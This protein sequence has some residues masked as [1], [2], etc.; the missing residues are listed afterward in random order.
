[1]IKEHEQEDI[2]SIRSFSKTYVIIDIYIYIYFQNIWVM[3]IKL[4]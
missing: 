1:M 4:P 3:P 2:S